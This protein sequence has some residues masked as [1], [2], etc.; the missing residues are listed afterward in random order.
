ML[1]WTLPLL[2]LFVAIAPT[3]FFSS[4]PSNVWLVYL[5]YSINSII[6]FYVSTVFFSPP[7]TKF[8]VPGSE[9]LREVLERKFN[10]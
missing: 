1:W 3:F 8:A 2:L 5:C 6:P 7:A 9:R 10:R 4:S